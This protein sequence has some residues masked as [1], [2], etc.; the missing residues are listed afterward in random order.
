MG[1]GHCGEGK[2]RGHSNLDVNAV[3]M[4]IDKS[5]MIGEMLGTKLLVNLVCLCLSV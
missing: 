4:K 3:A 1:A 5:Y 2:R